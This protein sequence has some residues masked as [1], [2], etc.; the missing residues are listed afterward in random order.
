MNK[1]LKIERVY[2]NPKD[3]VQIRTHNE[4]R[5]V[6][7]LSHENYTLRMQGMQWLLVIAPGGW[8]TWIPFHNIKSITEFRDDENDKQENGSED[9]EASS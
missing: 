7:V 1:N 9:S 5:S 6:S 8:R 3:K 2:L 4:T